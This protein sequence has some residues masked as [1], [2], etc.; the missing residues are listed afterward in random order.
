MS[1]HDNAVARMNAHLARREHRR[2]RFSTEERAWLRGREEHV[3][4]WMNQVDRAVANYRRVV[5]E[6]QRAA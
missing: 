4:N 1:G 2:M 3:V 6:E 5:A